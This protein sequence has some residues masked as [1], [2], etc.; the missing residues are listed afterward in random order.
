MRALT[1]AVRVH[2]AFRSINL[3][4][5]L[6]IIVLFIVGFCLK[7]SWSALGHFAELFDTL[8]ARDQTY[9][10]CFALLISRGSVDKQ[11]NM[12][13]RE[14]KDK[15]G[16]EDRKSTSSQKA[17]DGTTTTA[18]RSKS[19]TSST[20]STPSSSSGKSAES[21]QT[22]TMPVLSLATGSPNCPAG[23]TVTSQAPPHAPPSADISRTEA[24]VDELFR[25]MNCLMQKMDG[26][27]QYDRSSDDAH[28]LSS[29]D[30]EAEPEDDDPFERMSSIISNMADVN[31][32]GTSGH[33]DSSFSQVLADLA[34]SF[35]DEEEKG[36]PLT[37][38]LARILNTALRKKPVDS[39]V[40][41]TV[42]QFKLPA[43]V[44][45]LT[46]P[47]TNV[48]ISAAMSQ[49]GKKIDSNLS[50][51]NNLLARAIV[52]IAGIV[53]AIGLGSPKDIKAYLSDMNSSIRLVVA[54]FNYINQT[55]KLVAKAHIKEDALGKIC[56]WEH[57]V[58]ETQ[59]FPFDV[60]KKVE[61]MNK[62]KKLGSSSKKFKDQAFKSFGH[63]KSSFR[64]TPF[65]KKRP[66]S[67]GYQGHK[68]S[69]ANS[70]RPFLGKSQAQSSH[71]S[72]YRS[73]NY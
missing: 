20:R 53:N 13:D 8:E 62:T 56:R 18:S 32:P 38:E 52:P 51:I 28:S 40:K 30:E 35:H 70:S 69:Q 64:K 37:E 9:L 66:S 5:F 21:P 46:V 36:E 11:A 55:R 42:S 29:S 22:T 61:E 4:F 15:R 10:R 33:H 2:E 17:V 25:M 26:G 12:A 63:G 58:G 31:K 65:Y 49:D 39:A 1:P 59:L 67:Q 68:Y 44:P 73:K 54:A 71:K 45:N 23:G 57:E 72:S 41:A 60:T 43:N 3:T 7:C 50:Q 47:S 16:H 6:R 48:D 27:Q 24:R 19:T 34:G 14:R